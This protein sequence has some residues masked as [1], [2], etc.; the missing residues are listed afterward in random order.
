MVLYQYGN[1]VMQHIM[2]HGSPQQKTLV[3]KALNANLEKAALDIHAGAVLDS[4][5]F[6]AATQ[7]ACELAR[8][9]LSVEQ[10]LSKLATVQRGNRRSQD[11]V[12]R[13]IHI[14]D[15]QLLMTTAMQLQ[16]VHDSLQSSS[17][18]QS[19]LKALSQRHQV[20][21]PLSTLVLH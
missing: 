7:D 13:L 21:L 8:H 3:L 20:Y 1:F 12:K 17:G 10:L 18:G 6:F 11:T 14:V 19:I 4:A 15:N 2:E 16:D 9:L 5:M